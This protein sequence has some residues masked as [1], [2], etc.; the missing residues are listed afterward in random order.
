MVMKPEVFRGGKMS[1]QQKKRF[2]LHAR[3]SYKR[4]EVALLF[5]LT[6]KIY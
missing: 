5:A 6:F 2:I 4:E 3:N 1:A